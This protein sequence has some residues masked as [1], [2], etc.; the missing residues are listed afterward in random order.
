MLIGSGDKVNPPPNPP[1][2]RLA[3][4]ITGLALLSSALTLPTWVNYVS[5]TL[6]SFMQSLYLYLWFPLRLPRYVTPSR[7]VGL[8]QASFFCIVT[9]VCLCMCVFVSCALRESFRLIK[10]MIY[11]SM[12]LEEF[13]DRS[14]KRVFSNEL[15][16][17]N[18][19]QPQKK[20]APETH[21]R[22]RYTINTHRHTNLSLHIT[23]SDT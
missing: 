19:S 2:Q 23:P 10:E 22:M 15:S 17:L 21:A 13:P 18:H 5:S 3:D 12:M 6:S 1:P 8:Q 11:R 14:S 9:F 7:S 20:L 4:P 16:P